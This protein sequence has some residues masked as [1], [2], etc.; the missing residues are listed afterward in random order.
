MRILLVNH[1]FTIT[2]AST[3]LLRL[4]GHLAASGHAVTVFASIVTHGPVKDSYLALGI[5]V[6][7]AVD[8]KNYELA[9]CNTVFTAGIVVQAA[10]YTRTI[11]WIHE[12]QPGLN[13]LLNNL[14]FLRAFNEATA[15]V[16]QTP[17]QRDVVFRSF[18]YLLDPRKFFVIP[19]GV[20]VDA[21]E[22]P[23]APGAP[24]RRT[25][26]IVSVGTVE[27]RKRHDDII[28]AVDRL[29]SPGIECVIC[30][31]FYELAPDALKIV[32]SAPDRLMLIPDLPQR[33]CLAL[34]ASADIFCL[35]SASESQPLVVFEAALM[36]KPL[37]LS[38]LPVYDGIFTH[39]ANCL[40]FPPGDVE[41]LAHSLAMLAGS[42]GLRERLGQAAQAT[43]RRYSEAAFHAEF[44]ALL[45]RVLA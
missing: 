4:A 19:N 31:K 28:R 45:E 15:V 3:M 43:A 8:F 12:T 29:A 13:F 26:R 6:L 1:E 18:T 34:V 11:W 36:A 21:K 25:I 41:M 35:A 40:L 23:P 33:E 2:G 42:G 27:P 37:V 32:E 22:L 16:C 5:P 17:F 44:D 7:D 38:G 30:G 24:K 9:I 10:P 20:D 14:P 39:G